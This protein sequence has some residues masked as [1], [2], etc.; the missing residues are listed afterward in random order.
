MPTLK[1]AIMS[2]ENLLKDLSFNPSQN[3]VESIRLL[4]WAGKAYLD[5]RSRE[6]IFSYPL[7]PGET[8]K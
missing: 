1:E 6:G 2:N 5:F 3:E 7:L 8:L 4:I